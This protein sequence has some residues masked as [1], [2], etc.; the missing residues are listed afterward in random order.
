MKIRFECVDHITGELWFRGRSVTP[1]QPCPICRKPTSHERREGYCAIDIERGIVWCGHSADEARRAFYRISDAA[2]VQQ[3]TTV[4]RRAKAAADVDWDSQVEACQC[5]LAP[6]ILREQAK[7]LGVSINSLELMDTG[8]HADSGSLAWP[9]RNAAG[10]TV[11]IRL[12]KP[13]GFKFAVS[14]STNALFIP[15]NLDLSVSDKIVIVEGPTD[16]AA[17]I[18]LSLNPIGRAS[19]RTCLKDLVQ[20]CRGKHVTI[21]RDQGDKNG[22]GEKG[23]NELAAELVGQCRFVSVVTPMKS[24]DV[25]SWLRE[26]AT[27]ALA[28]SV[29]NNAS[30][31]RP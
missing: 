7:A 27:P 5:D 28:R 14:G 18:D 3:P 17:A 24:K 16:T 29:I 31:W 30:A 12:R 21:I 9:M 13:S 4:R 11:G 26:G 8:W 6:S 10:V 20:I 22:D 19:A 15:N 2:M 1:D 25:R 23:A